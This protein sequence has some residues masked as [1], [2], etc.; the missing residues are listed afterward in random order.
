MDLFSLEED[1][2]YEGLFITQ[3]SSNSDNSG[4]LGNP[5]D[6]T[7]PC[8]SLEAQKGHGAQYSDISDYDFDIPSSQISQDRNK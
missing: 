8:V 1:D 7:S 2:D 3:S 6:F 4:L 5:E